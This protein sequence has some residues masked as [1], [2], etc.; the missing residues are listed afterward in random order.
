[1]IWVGVKIVVINNKSS[2]I[3]HEKRP[4]LLGKPTAMNG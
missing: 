3:Q 2:M 1:M 4:Q